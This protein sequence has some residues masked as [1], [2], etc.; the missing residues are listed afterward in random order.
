MMHGVNASIIF[1][2]YHRMSVIL[3]A[4]SQRISKTT[5]SWRDNVIYAPPSPP[6]HVCATLNDLLIKQIKFRFDYVGNRHL[7]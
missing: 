5:R 4:N 6:S 1:I 3:I 2:I 7:P